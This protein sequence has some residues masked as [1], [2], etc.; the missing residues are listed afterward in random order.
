MPYR[1]K[2]IYRGRR[3]FRVP[4]TIALFVVAAL[5]VGAV[6]LFYALQQFIVYDQS[7]VSLQ[8]PF[9]QPAAAETEGGEAAATPEPTLE[10]VAVQVVYEDPD[11][12]EVDLGGW[13]GLPPTRALFIP[14][15]DATSE[16]KLAAAVSNAI[17]GGFTGVVL[18]LK[19]ESGQL[20]WASQSETALNY[21]TAGVMELAGT[22]D[23]LHEA[24]LTAAAQLS[25]CADEL[26]ARRNWLVTLQTSSGGTYVDEDGVYW[27]DPY[28]RTVR[29]YIAE[30][31]A[32]LTAMGFDEIVLADLYHP[33]SEEGFTYSVTL[34]TEADP[35]M[36][37][38]QMARRLVELSEGDAAVSAL[39]DEDSLRNGLSAQTGQDIDV[40][41]R[42]FAR[43][44]CPSSA[45]MAASD[46]ELAVDR[47][48][49]GNAAARFVPVCSL[50]PEG[51]GSY[52]I[53]N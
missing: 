53:E 2:D 45:D 33:I 49:S 15:E 13:E 31:M 50:I 38:C 52:V 30:L 21:G 22:L 8:L 48:H 24:G 16:T 35:V 29:N 23:T 12:S 40:F 7:G 51:M 9:M 27:L 11:F 39:I 37:V 20:A 10:P 43:L 32:E 46:L 4:L 26:M 42:I 36:A 6:G 5:V 25:C 14:Y 19:D 17:A 41:W 18:Q 44:Y 3:K 28:N 34:Q 47:M 1:P